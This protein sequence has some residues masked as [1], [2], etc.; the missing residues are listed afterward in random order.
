[1]KGGNMV[2]QCGTWEMIPSRTGDKVFI[3]CGICSI[4]ILQLIQCGVINFQWICLV[5][6]T[7]FPVTIYATPSLDPT[8]SKKSFYSK[9]IFIVGVHSLDVQNDMIVISGSIQSLVIDVTVRC[10]A[11]VV[12][13]STRE[14]QPTNVTT[15][16]ATPEFLFK[17]S[18][19]WLLSVLQC[20]IR[21][22][23]NATATVIPS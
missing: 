22:C 14:I 20:G 19:L 3:E 6:F 12:T 15:W 13:Y 23:R 10:K 7:R 18:F 17:I 11:P 21:A 9:C 2:L 16:D 5:G 8:Y 4:S 1:M